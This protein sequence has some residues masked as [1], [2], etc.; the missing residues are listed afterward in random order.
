MSSKRWAIPCWFFFHGLAEKISKS[1][2]EK[3]YEA[4]YGL[5]TLISKNLPCPFCRVHAARY[6]QDKKAKDVNTKKK[7]KKFL[8]TFHN[9]VNKRI[10]H[11]VFTEDILLKFKNIDME[12]SYIF[13]NTQF[14][15]AYVINHDF[16]GWRRNMVQENVKD[17][18]RD[19]WGDMFRQEDC[20]ED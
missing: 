3:E 4:V 14:Y 2:Y 6:L 17:Y 18:L 5:I 16:N 11:S 12:K 1:F 20:N 9:A 19:R 15:G 13:F 7:L 8:F 10:G